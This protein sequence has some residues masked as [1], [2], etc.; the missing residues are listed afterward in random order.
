MVETLVIILLLVLLF[1]GEPLQ[2]QNEESLKR[3]T[4]FETSKGSR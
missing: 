2:K 1:G 3:L 4:D